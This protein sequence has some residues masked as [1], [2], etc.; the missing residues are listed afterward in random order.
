MV[1]GRDSG[2]QDRKLEGGVSE[3]QS[4]PPPQVRSGG[5]GIHPAVYI[6]YDTTFWQLRG[7]YVLTRV[8]DYGSH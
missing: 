5:N 4:S 1:N 6:V 2:E 3:K 7:E 8:S